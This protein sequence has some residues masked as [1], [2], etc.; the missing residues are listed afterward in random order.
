MKISPN[1]RYRS[2][3]AEG[4]ADIE[5]AQ[6]LRYLCF[7]AE[8]G[9]DASGARAD[10][11]D[12]DPFDGV[13][14]HVLIEDTQT[15]EL[16]GAFRLMALPNGKGIARSYSAQ[17][18]ALDGLA[19]YQGAM[20][21]M[22]RFCIAPGKGHPDILRVAWAEMARFV[23]ATDTQLLFGC[24]SFQGCEAD[25]YLEAFT[26]LADRHLA[27]RRWRPRIKAPSVFRFAERLRRRQ[28][29]AKRALLQVPPLLRSYLSMGGWVSDH[30]VVDRDLGTL[31]VFTG[32]EIAKMPQARKRAL[33][34]IAG[35]T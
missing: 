31:H 30:A 5:A 25:A 8:T 34:A 11:R 16:V 24:S 15:D 9:A 10:G 12:S 32:L 6:R 18:Y 29:D 23:D 20:V 2:R 27:P 4:P 26:L 21:E 13:C 28:P 7:I 33:R 1:A 17:F 3:V 22:G 14:Q 19:A 35:A